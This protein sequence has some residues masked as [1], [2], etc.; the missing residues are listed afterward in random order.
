MTS[1][2]LLIKSTKTELINISSANINTESPFQ[3]IFING[4]QIKPSDS[5]KY[6]E[7]KFDNKLNF[8]QHIP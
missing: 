5:T 1:N 6:L 7:V 3:K 8:D 4:M 2:S